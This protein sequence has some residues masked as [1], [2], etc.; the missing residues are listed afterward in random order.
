M[1][2]NERLKRALGIDKSSPYFKAYVQ[3]TNA[4]LAQ[5]AGVA[6]AVLQVLLLMNVFMLRGA[7]DQISNQIN[8][9]HAIS[10]IVFGVAS[11]GLS[12]LAYRCLRVQKERQLVLPIIIYLFLAVAYGIF[13][14]YLDSYVNDPPLT[15]IFCMVAS[16]CVFVI[17][18]LGSISMNAIA[19]IVFNRLANISAH[20]PPNLV[21]H[22]WVGWV[23]VTF[24]AIL[25][26][27][28][29][30]NGASYEEELRDASELDELTGMRNRRSLREDFGKYESQYLFVAMCDLDDFK[31]INDT[32]G[33]VEGD[34][35]LVAFAEAILSVFGDGGC[36]RYGGDEFLVV[37]SCQS[38]AEFRQRIGVFRANFATN[39]RSTCHMDY[40]PTT[41]VGFAYGFATTADDLRT[42]VHIA[43]S[44][45]YDV[46]RGT[47]G[48]MFGEE[49]KGNEVS[50]VTH[51]E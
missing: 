36:Y 18:P 11:V 24:V 42:M 44:S 3:R 46:K 12:V 20:F 7:S 25:R 51:Q 15:F 26:Y 22:Y 21:F 38:L 1:R 39:I 27:Q 28:E 16:T 40:M 17:P 43:D 8:Q 34:I 30:R 14:S 45:L 19:F 2:F 6:V 10:Y 47:K 31:S 37:S 5:Y 13:N 23:I 29:C 49:F 9:A 35:V 41:S 50:E 4:N 33:H 48:G 32:Y